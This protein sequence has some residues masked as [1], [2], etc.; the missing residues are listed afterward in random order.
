MKKMKKIATAIVAALAAVVL[1][2]AF[3][4]CAG[5]YAGTYK[6]SSMNM[7]MGGVTVELKANEAFMGVTI[8]EDAY[9]LEVKDDNTWTLSVNF[10]GET[11]VESGT[12]RDDG[13]LI[14]VASDGSEQSVDVNGNNLVMS[15]SDS[16][17]S[18]SITFVKQ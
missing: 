8:T 17:M 3:A 2:V 9:V 10:M 7:D 18:A 11:A 12:W 5:N 15:Y 6:F 14:L 16:D 1:A 13:G 4:A